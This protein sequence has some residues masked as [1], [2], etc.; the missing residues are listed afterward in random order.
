MPFFQKSNC[1]LYFWAERGYEPGRPNGVRDVSPLLTWGPPRPKHTAD[2]PGLTHS[3]LH[4]QYWPPPHVTW[5][6]GGYLICHVAVSRDHVEGGCSAFALTNRTY[7]LIFWWSRS[8][9]TFA[10]WIEQHIERVIMLVCAHSRSSSVLVH[11]CFHLK[12]TVKT[13]ISFTR[14]H[15]AV[16]CLIW[17]E[18]DNTKKPDDQPWTST[19]RW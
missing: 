1:V 18:L 7:L 4:P 14:K 19:C 16:N 11:C 9:L 17:S 2:P 12:H 10:E 13:F 8:K 5:S 15:K 6:H 3:P